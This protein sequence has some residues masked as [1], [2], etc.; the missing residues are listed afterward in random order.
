M[1]VA[2]SLG[3]PGLQTPK[4]ATMHG[5]LLCAV[6]DGAENDDAVAQAVA[7]SERLGLRLV[8]AHVVDRVASPG[9][10]DESVTMRGDHEAAERELAELAQDHQV[11]ATADRRVVVGDPSALLAQIAGEEAAD[12]IVVGAR[13]RGWGRRGLESPLAEELGAETPVPVLIAP[14]R[15]RR[16]LRRA[17]PLT[18]RHET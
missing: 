1:V 6:T 17:A 16:S 4:E 2:E 3:E 14:P 8:L 12:V 9:D 5:T 10:G 11:S 15:L 13:T 18:S 7:L